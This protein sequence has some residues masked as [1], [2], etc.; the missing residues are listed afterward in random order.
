LPMSSLAKHSFTTLPAERLLAAADQV[1]QEQ[2][3]DG[4]HLRGLLEISNYCRR[5]CK[6]CGL[7]CHY[8]KVKRYRMSATEIIRQVDLIDKLGYGTVVLQAG[9]DPGLSLDFIAGIV[10]A[11]KQ[12]TTMAVTLSLGERS[13]NDYAAWREAGA[14]RY[15]LKFESSNAELFRR[16]HPGEKTGLDERL[17]NLW[18]LHTLGYEV[19]S[20]FM[21]GLPGQTWEDLDNDISLSQTLPLAMIGVGPYIENEFIGPRAGENQVPAIPDVVIRTTAK[22]RLALPSANI[23]ATTALSTISSGKG[24]W[25]ALQAGAN[26]IMPN[27]TPIEYRRMY[28]LYPRQMPPTTDFYEQREELAAQVKMIG[29]YL[30]LSASQNT[31][32]NLN[33]QAANV[34]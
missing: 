22:L 16:Y 14:D 34:N 20:G 18:Q 11:V 17:D 25:Q 13:K 7:N 32:L 4:I 15:L 27:M 31:D 5:A 9:E 19:G 10:R 28:Q 21:L 1:R 6:Y 8:T 26:V 33:E 12:S 23:P 29:R 30:H 24:R 3:G 2:A